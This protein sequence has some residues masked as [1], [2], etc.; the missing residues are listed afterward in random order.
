VTTVLYDL[1]DDNLYDDNLYDDN[2]LLWCAAVTLATGQPL[3]PP[4]TQPLHIAEQLIANGY[5]MRCESQCCLTHIR[6][7]THATHSV[8]R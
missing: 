2:L 6:D 7:A 1:C 5:R 3:Q 8:M 4:L